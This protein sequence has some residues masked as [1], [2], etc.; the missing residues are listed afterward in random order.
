MS[1]DRGRCSEFVGKG[2]ESAHLFS[3]AQLFAYI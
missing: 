3:N 1:E 2:S